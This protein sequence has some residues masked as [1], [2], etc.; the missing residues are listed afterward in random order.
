ME[1]IMTRATE[2]IV[3][4]SIPVESHIVRHGDEWYDKDERAD[5]DLLRGMLDEIEQSRKVA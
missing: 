2:D 4:V 3:G 1:G 5:F